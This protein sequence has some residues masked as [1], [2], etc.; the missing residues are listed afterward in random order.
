M[1]PSWCIP[2]EG[3]GYQVSIEDD[4]SGKTDEKQMIDEFK[5]YLYII[6]IP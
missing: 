3:S 1:V 2:F 4:K 6:Y 5:K